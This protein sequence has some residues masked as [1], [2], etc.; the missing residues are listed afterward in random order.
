MQGDNR[1][2]LLTTTRFGRCGPSLLLLQQ[3]S[4]TYFA[5]RNNIAQSDGRKIPLLVS[6]DIT[7]LSLACGVLVTLASESV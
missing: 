5:V 4:F 6:L 3:K 2:R 1:D 7:V